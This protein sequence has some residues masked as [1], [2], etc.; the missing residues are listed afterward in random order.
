MTHTKSI[1]SGRG[2]ERRWAPTAKPGSHSKKEALTLI[3]I[4][5]DLLG[6]ADNAREV[7]RILQNSNVTVDKKVVKES[8]HPV[9]LMDVVEIPKLKKQFCVLPSKKGLVLKEVDSKK[10]AAKLCAVREKTKVKKGLIQ[11]NLHDGSNMLVKD[12]KYK[13]GDSLLI[14]LPDKKIKKVFGFKEGNFGLVVSGRHCGET[15]VIKEIQPGTGTTR[16]LTTLGELQTPSKYIFVV[17]EKESE[18]EL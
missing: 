12:D 9:G 5:R 3:Q 16:S 1:A 15:G 4:L 14:T 8:K 13:P 17:G 10:A 7:R 6:Y 18:I 11:L 2:K